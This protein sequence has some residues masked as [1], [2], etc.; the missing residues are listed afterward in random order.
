VIFRLTLNAAPVTIDDS[1]GVSEDMM[2]MIDAPGVLANDSDADG[3]RL[4]AM[5]VTPPAHGAVTLNP[6]GSFTYTPSW[7]YHGSDSFTYEAEDGAGGTSMA[8]V[9]IAV[10]P[11]NDAPVA[12]G[13]TASTIAG[14]P[15]SGVLTATDAD[16]DQ[17]FYTIVTNGTKGTA[18]T[19]DHGAF[20]YTPNSGAAG[21]DTF[22]FVANDG[23]ATSNAATVVVTIAGLPA[24][25]SNLTA[26]AQYS[27]AGKNKT[28]QGVRL[29]WVDNSSDETLF[30]IQRCQI[31]GKGS[32]LACN[33][34]STFNVT[35]PVNS[36]TYLDGTAVARATYRYRVRSENAAGSSGWIEVQ[37][38]VP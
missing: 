4:A 37:I 26:N 2:L 27:G 20:V 24:A 31:T 14:R 19:T 32:T 30:R 22:T 28:L 7:D 17:L 16:G 9:S 3:N 8:T 34:T 13:G 35:V 15:V 6:N 33:Y 21:T 25:P 5:L 23:A 36:V 38:A 18:T 10:A 12:Q 11:V 29:T 1:Y